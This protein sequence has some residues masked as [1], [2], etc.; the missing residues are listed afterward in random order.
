MNDV[1]I[2]P[3]PFYDETILYNYIDSV[4]ES[5]LA[6]PNNMKIKVNIIVSESDQSIDYKKIASGISRFFM[7]KGFSITNNISNKEFIISWRA[8]D[9]SQYDFLQDSLKIE[10]LSKRF[11][12]KDIYNCVTLNEDLRSFNYYHLFFKVKKEIKNMVLYNSQI[13]SIQYL[14]T[15]IESDVLNQIYKEDIDKL[16]AIFADY[17]FTFVNS[18]KFFITKV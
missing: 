12:A 3:G 4:Y 7:N 15:S 2:N 16:N 6:N 17:E 5:I 11:N 18:G 1:I 14:S 13:S 8:P 9:L 10:D